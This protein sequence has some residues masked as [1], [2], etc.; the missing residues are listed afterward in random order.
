MNHTPGPWNTG[1]SPKNIIDAGK[2]LVATVADR[3][4]GEGEEANAHLITA[5]PDLLEALYTA[6]P[7]IESAESDPYI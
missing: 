3:P 6:L 2:L 5:A 7:Y 1:H 4:G